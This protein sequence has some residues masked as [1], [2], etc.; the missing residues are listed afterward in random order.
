MPTFNQ[1]HIKNYRFKQLF[2]ELGW[3][4]PAQ[5][6]PYSVA[7]G[8]DTWLLDVVALKKG[9]QVL[10]CRP[11]A[12]GQLPDYATRQKI[13]RKVTPDVREHLIVFTNQAKTV[14]IW[15]WVTRQSGKPAQYREVF[16]RQGEAPELLTQKL[17]RLHFTLDE[18][19]LL[20]VL[21]VTARMDDA[22]P[23]DKVTKKFYGEFEKQR[24]AFAAFIEGIP[25]DSEDQ[26][27]YTAV[28]I[29][30]LMF[31][32][33]LQEKRFLDNQPKYLQDRLKT[34]LDGKHT[35]S[36][37]KRFLSPLFF[38]GFAQE[39]TPENAAAIQAEFGKVPYLNGGLFAQHELEE[40][41]GEALDIADSA[42]QKLFAFFNDWD[43]HLDDRPLKSGKEINPDVLGYIFEKFVNQK[44]MGAYYTKEDITEYIGKN[45]II[46]AL[47]GKVRAEHPAAFDALAWPLL[48]HSGDAYI[49]PAMLKGVDVPY[50]SD[51]ANGLDT[52]AP[53]LLARRKPWN[54]RADDAVSLP[55]EI[56]REAI[57]RHQRTR[58][59]R[60]KLAAGE[61]REVGDLITW[62]LNIRQFAQ[63]L[64]ERCTDV[65]LLKS[66]WFNLAGRLPRRS[67]EK[68][69]HG[70]SVL[71]PTCGSGAF[72]FAA[73][74]ILKPLYDATL[75]TLQA[76][77]VD[78]L[79]AGD[80]SHPEK[81]AEVDELLNRFAA[82]S[83]DRAQDYAVIKHII[84]HNLYGVDIEKQATEIAKLRLFLKLV[85]LLEAGDEIEP[86]PDIDFNIRHGNT[87][88]G[89]ATADETEKA[90]KG[91]T[92]GNLFSDA[93]E[94]IRIRLSVVEQQYN[95]FQIQ[96]VQRGG[97]VS[98]ADKQA[99]STTLSE[100]EEMLNYHLAREY[101]VNTTKAKDFDAWKISHRP[102]HWYVDYHPLISSGGFDAIIGNPPYVEIHKV[103]GY[104]PK[105]DVYPTAA[106]G[107]LYAPML[108]RALALCRQGQGRVG[109]IIPISCV[110]T[111]RMQPLR[112]SWR[113]FRAKTWLSHYSGDAHPSVLFEGVKFRLTIILQQIGVADGDN[114]FSSPF[115]RWFPEARQFLFH[116]VCYTEVIPSLIRQGLLPKLPPEALPILYALSLQ[117][118][119]IARSVVSES[120]HTAYAH[121]IVAHYIKAF[122]FIPF[123]RSERDGQ[124]RSEDYK[125]FPLS[126]KAELEA[127]SGL[128]N[129][130]V[131]YLWF[132][133]YSDVFHC[134]RELILDFPV[135]L[136]ELAQS[137]ALVEK[138][139][140]LMKAYRETAVRREIP[141]KAT[142]LV[143]YDE[144]YPRKVK[145][146]I[147]KVDIVLGPIVGLTDEQVDF[148]CNFDLKFR[149]LAEP[150]DK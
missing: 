119:N 122:D 83:S 100:L 77:R 113:R 36:F 63:D 4:A 101:G 10:H 79:I 117:N 33:F 98:V 18:E 106:C 17:S 137:T 15:Q 93:W 74:N 84:V 128:L 60:A 31:L 3:D 144:F 8:D 108:E 38:K 71:D 89:Y 81:W 40:R 129:S 22:A 27:W 136:S 49:Y 145:D 121:R 97:H 26:R 20:T 131:F 126:T 146:E 107:N 66:F 76:V 16:F 70:L 21:G 132:V 23:R 56:W 39:R 112:D 12:L 140:S 29:D 42:F 149:T 53:D 7:V 139:N 130:S 133:A 45:T 127:F 111:A 95:Q 82:A 143:E 68:F 116:Q 135:N 37:Y 78:A 48:Q 62:N 87:L 88:V 51:I 52:Q 90:V 92:Q 1:E 123:F 64:I 34:H 65:A 114:A 120:V 94:D 91:A 141:Y 46:P 11:G 105:V 96:Q 103:E 99:L 35:Q 13:E 2:N 9:V 125:P 115:Q 14:Q 148:V 61:L 57:A 147:D 25:A 28:V 47:L 110:S 86:L 124:K 19:K 102:F 6:Q 85:A 80:T 32:W 41:Y 69:R 67:N 75:R 134:G 109:Q 138:T 50:P 142:G 43:W 118:R 55:T 30:R 150:V 59:V 44:Q 24:K 54:K 104:S 72:L 58:E 73:L 5:Q